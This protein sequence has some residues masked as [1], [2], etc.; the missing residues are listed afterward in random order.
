M[1][2][3]MTSESGMTLIET[4]VAMCVL[5]VGAVGMASV[6]LHGMDGA[7]SAPNEL[8]A[9]QKAAEAVESV[10]SARDSH[11]KTWAQLSNVADGGIFVDAE[12]DMKVAGNDGILNTAD[13]GDIE[14]VHLPG[15]DGSVGT[16]DDE[17]VGLLGFKR[18]IAIA[19]FCDPAPTPPDVCRL[20]QIIVV[21]TYPA[22]TVTRTYTL[23]ALISA[24][25]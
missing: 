23:T 24:F 15:P 3:R 19:D 17:E 7:I 8:I 13:D 20:R 10:Y 22:G 2:K 5:T 25:A 18:R 14:T 16:P 11:T 12:T 4:L 1:T 9:T 21:I 6:F